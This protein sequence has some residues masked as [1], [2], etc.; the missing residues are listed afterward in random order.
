MRNVVEE[1][2]L[3]LQKQQYRYALHVDIAVQLI[4][5]VTSDIYYY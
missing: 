1:I 3:N 2:K 4:S 5:N